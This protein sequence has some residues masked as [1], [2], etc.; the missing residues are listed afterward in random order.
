MKPG[1]KSPA[2]LVAGFSEE[3]GSIVRLAKKL[4][5]E[6]PNAQSE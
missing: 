3:R 6:R 4:K 2:P 1:G 5:K